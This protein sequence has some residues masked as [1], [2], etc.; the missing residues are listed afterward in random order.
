MHD[1]CKI[2]KKVCIITCS[3]SSFDPRIFYKEAKSFKKFGYDVSVIAPSN[4]NKVHIAESINVIEIKDSGP[5]LIRWF[6]LLIRIFR[7]SLKV[8]ADIYHC[9]EPDLFPVTTLLR[10][11]KKKVIYEVRESH[12]DIISV[13]TW[14]MKLY[15]RFTLSV[16]E[17]LFCRYFDVIITTDEC[18]AKRYKNFNK[19]VYTIF[20]F[21]PFEVFKP[22]DDQDVGKV[23]K[24][25]FVIIYVGGMT[26]ERGILELIKAV[27]KVS[28]KCPMVKLLLA[29]W[30]ATKDFEH[31]C[32]GYVKSND[33]TNNVDFLGFIPHTGIQKYIDA[34]DIGAV[35]L[36]PIPKFYKNIPIKQF[37]YML[38]EK[39]VLGS[40]LPPID[41]FVGKEKAGILVDPNNINAIAEAIIYLLEHPEEAKKMGEN[42]RRAVEEKYNWTEMEKEL[43][44]IYSK[45]VD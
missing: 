28:N 22:S 27:H 15:L 40:N 5:R 21:P 4:T 23:Y 26:D 10:I 1:A 37:E 11:L 34:A 30:F 36:K 6:L 42:G 39:P 16:L 35:L 2:S 8:H 14:P 17:P 31:E 7:E 3:D 32:T 18:I 9:H 38:C 13:T 29:G 24:D 45:L 25:Y 19:K 43:L 12:T 33:I 44:K 20:N 41:N